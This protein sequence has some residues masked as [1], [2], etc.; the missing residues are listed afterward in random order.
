MNIHDLACAMVDYFKYMEGINRVAMI[1]VENKPVGWFTYLI[2]TWEH[3]KIFHD[4]PMFSLM[5]DEG[6]GPVIYIDYVVSN[7]W[8]REIRD[9]IYQSLK[10]R[11]KEV[12]IFVWYR[13]S[14]KE[15]RMVVWEPR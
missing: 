3:V 9:S 5:K 13:P 15:D 10:D 1:Y 6:T 7:V 12:K 4:R 8:S 14:A 11:H 2:G